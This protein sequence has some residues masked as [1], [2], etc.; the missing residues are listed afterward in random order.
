MS[1][2]PKT[3]EWTEGACSDGVVILRDGVPASISD[4][5]TILN[6]HETQ[7]AKRVRWFREDEE[8]RARLRQGLS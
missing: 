2:E 3:A 7:Q 6:Q 4:I 1:D 5:L 8:L